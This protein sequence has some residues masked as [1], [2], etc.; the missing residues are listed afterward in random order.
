MKTRWGRKTVSM[1][2]DFLRLAFSQH[3]QHLSFLPTAIR[4]ADFLI[5]FS[6]NIPRG[7][8]SVVLLSHTFIP[9]LMHYRFWFRKYQL[10]AT[11][12]RKIMYCSLLYSQCLKFITSNWQ[13]RE[14]MND[15]WL[16]S[17][18][19]YLLPTYWLL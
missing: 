8:N 9:Y 14:W 13:V 15:N 3:P 11:K 5:D 7:N 10:H 19:Q 2:Y 6:S 18:L 16:H 4:L 17:S 12:R 1:V